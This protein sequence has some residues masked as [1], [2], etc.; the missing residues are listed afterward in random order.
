ML[1]L[2][3]TG[4]AAAADEPFDGPSNWGATGL[5]EIPTARVMREGRFRFGIGQANPYR[6]YTFAISPLKGLEIDGRITE[7]IGVP[8]LLSG[9]G[10]FKD[11]AVDLKYQVI[12][13]G[14]WWP[15]V[16]IGIMDPHGTRIYPG[17]YIVASKQIYPFDFTIGFGNGR[18]GKRPLAA[19]G[20]G[21][22]AEILDD[23][24][25]WRR[26]GQFFWGVQFALTEEIL[27][28]AEYSPIRYEA[29]TH[30]P[31]QKR[32]FTEPVPSPYNFGIRWRPWNWL[33]ADLSWQRGDQIG[34]NLSA[35]FDLGVPLIP[36]YDRPY[37]E[38]PE[39]RLNPVEERI[40]R[41]LQETGFSDILVRKDGDR[42]AVEARNDKY[43]YTPR[44][45]SVMLRVVSEFAPTEVHEIRLIVTENGIP[46]VA[47]STTREDAGLFLS[48]KITA[49]EFLRLNGEGSP[50][51]TDIFTG[52]TGKKFNREWWD[53]KILPAFRM[54]LNDPSGFF[55]YRLGVRG[56][57]S[58]YPWRGATFLT[59]LEWYPLNNV[60]SSNIPSA[61]AVRSDI[62]LYQENKEVL[63][64]LLLQ[65][66][67]K[68]PWQIHGRAAAGILEVQFAG[69]DL[70]V[71]RPFFGGRLMLGLSG[72]IVKKRD[73]DSLLGLKENGLKSHYETAFLN[74][75]LNIP[76][77]EAAVDLKT[78]QFLAGDRG[79]V[80]TLSKF[81]N[82]VVLS[83]W[84]SATNT[85]GFTDPFNR[86][87]HDKGVA[88][89]LP[90]RL[91]SRTDSRTVYSFG[92]S[93]WTRDVAQDIEH[94]T[95]LFDYMG[96]NTEI[97]LKKDA[98]SR[99]GRGAGLR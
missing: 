40:A 28:M 88:I 4:N 2:L 27:L 75:R 23:N 25:S 12:P 49:R 39:Y 99:D 77:M 62:A 80:L 48:E 78:G 37:K 71:A 13:E 34:V 1:I 8:A 3:L 69:I 55:K 93:P 92:I 87:Y 54:F 98:V 16:A 67:E 20:E 56:E 18:F 76:E 85:D 41:G 7:V 17:Q 36:L 65:Q 6:Y 82:G 95:T 72:S 14:K 81:F 79:T 50:F 35:A 38:R 29:Q 84:Y 70:E 24:A 26:D 83:A 96:R 91:F 30:D 60:S 86:G 45:L 53:Y 57:V 10:D 74:T 66:I 19:K 61:E 21:F 94:F 58:V 22:A 89:S 59:G 33:E 64:S 90:L 42:L 5:M 46:V 15:A 31:A 44:A 73:P 68:F 63:G 52:M 51:Q 9:Y 97:Y 43:Y 47:F 32:Y 11:K